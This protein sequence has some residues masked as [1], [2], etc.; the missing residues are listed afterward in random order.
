MS[1]GNARTAPPARLPLFGV[2]IEIYVKLKPKNEVLTREKKRTNPDSLP[3]YWRLWDFDLKN[4]YG[5]DKQR[6]AVFQRREVCRAVQANIDTML[7]QDNGWRCEADPSLKERNLTVPTDPRKWWG[8]EVISP[9]MSVSKQW[10][11]EIEMVFK[12]IG[13]TFDIWTD[14]D[15]A[16]HVHVSPGPTKATDY[17]LPQ[18]VRMAKGAFFWEEALREFLPPQRRYN[19]YALANYT[20]FATDQ[21]KAVS[22]TG[23]GPVFAEIDAVA[24]GRAGQRKFL[25]AIQGGI[26]NSTRYISTNFDAFMDIGT[27]EFRRQAGVASAT[28]TVHRILLAVTLHLSALR[29]DFDG[30]KSRLT[31]PSSEELRKELA[32]C[33]KKLPDTCHGSRFVNWLNWCLEVYKDGK[34]FSEQQINDREEALRKGKP[35]PNQTST[36]PPP[37]P[38]SQVNFR[39][40]ATAPPPMTSLGAALEYRSQQASTSRAPAAQASTPSRAPA[41]DTAS[42]GRQTPA[43]GRA[44][45]GRDAAPQATPV[46]ASTGRNG[47][48]PAAAGRA[49][50][51]RDAAP[52]PQGSTTAPRPRAAARDG[53]APQSQGG[54]GPRSPTSRASTGA[55]Q[56]SAATA[57]SGSASTST[58]TPRAPARARTG[59]TRLVERPAASSSSSRTA[60]AAGASN[61]GAAASGRTPARRRQGE[62]SENP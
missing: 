13:K 8:V 48:P 54:A 50:V 43:A 22:R 11:L 35:L 9:P 14:E 4:D 19:S 3:E 5:P 62:G 45:T 10:Q 30:A 59:T 32:G 34:F 16:C 21:Y 44:P 40:H 51:G 6:A 55:P 15:C 26:I 60:A 12:A 24:V 33:V 42:Q 46:R 41:R 58:S 28:T 1:A 2:E 49:S 25:E 61:G 7:G 17:T 47:A 53:A 29:Y 36:A 20:V 38:L 56:A 23:W 52:P 57:T 27:V 18:L 37:D 39:S 31:Y